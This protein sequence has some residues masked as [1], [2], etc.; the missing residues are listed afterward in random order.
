MVTCQAA[1]CFFPLSPA[2]QEVASAL[3]AC[4]RFGSAATASRS[5]DSAR[6]ASF[7]QDSRKRCGGWPNSLLGAAAKAKT[8]DTWINH[9]LRCKA[10]AMIQSNEP[11]IPK[12][13]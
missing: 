12:R 5:W 11:A 9:I 10:E 4:S 13:R 6:V 7:A 8:H 3:C 2:H 1:H